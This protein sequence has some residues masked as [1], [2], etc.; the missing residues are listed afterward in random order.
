M[1]NMWKSFLCVFF[2]AVLLLAANCLS[3]AMPA[4]SS[5]PLTDKLPEINLNQTADMK[6]AFLG[7][8]SEYV[9]QTQ[10]SYPYFLP[11]S[12]SQFAYPNTMTWS[13]N[14][15]FAF[16]PFSQDVSDSLRD[17][18]FYSQGIAY[19]NATLLDALLSQIQDL[20]IPEH[21]YLLAFM[22][23][24][25]ATDHSWFYVPERPD[26]LLNTTDITPS[27][28]YTGSSLPSNFGGI[29]RA[30]Y[31]DLSAIMEDAPTQSLVTGTIARFVS[32]NL[33]SMF[34]NLLGALDPAFAAADAQTY[35]NYEV[36]IL[37]LNGTGDQLSLERIREEFED[38]M[39]W[40]SWSVTVQTGPA[41]NA[42]NDLVE[43]LTSELPTPARYSFI[44]SNGSS[45]SFEARRNLAWQPVGERDPLNLYVYAHVKDYFGLTDLED[46][47]VIPILLLQLDNDTKLAIDG[48]GGGVCQ[49]PHNVII[50]CFDGSLETATGE[51]GPL[52]LKDVL[53]HEIGHWLSLTHQYQSDPQDPLGII[54]PMG[55]DEGDFC[56]FCRDA[57][58]RMSFISYYNQSI[59]LLSRNETKAAILAGELN[60][61]LQLFYNWEYSAAVEKIA[62][63]YFTLDTTPPSI[64]A[65]SQEPLQSSVS[66]EDEVEVRATVT[67]DLSGVKRVTLNY[68]TNNG[69]WNEVEMTNV[70]G[71]VWNGTIPAYSPGTNV[72]YVIVA[73][74]GFNNVITSQET[75]LK[76]EYNVVPEL[77]LPILILF[78]LTTLL[79]VM[80]RRKTR[81][82]S[83][84]KRQNKSHGSLRPKESFPRGS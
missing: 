1:L 33:G 38:F 20:A 68:T 36:K 61:S 15:S 13:F 24:P 48:L 70:E 34:P 74:D 80:V 67:D 57:R 62:S 82:M 29:R 49:F 71:S 41:E 64:I 23:I 22:W 39:P 12:F 44:L 18:A 43:N 65:V 69:T 27:G 50:V 83:F 19:F 2:A 40:T 7:V 47:S 46:K 30:L 8:P 84:G 54:C 51:I 76:Y 4:T 60:D 25:N 14:Y 78:I 16:Y 6:L 3:A 53:I 77:P 37:W 17:N 75:G 52:L 32:K 5:A 72:T 63:V 42:L 35:R 55:I 11:H 58:A 45:F 31:F 79:A 26:L 10:L 66:P 81:P 28:N 56:A 21:G 73:E 59:E 9:N